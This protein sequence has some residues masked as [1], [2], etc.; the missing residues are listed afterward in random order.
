M[1]NDALQPPAGGVQYAPTSE[2]TVIL[3]DAPTG[4]TCAGVDVAE[5]DAVT[6]VDAPPPPAVRDREG[7]AEREGDTVLDVVRDTEG[8]AAHDFV[9]VADSE[10][11]GEIQCIVGK[12]LNAADAGGEEPLHRGMTTTAPALLAVPAPAG[13]SGSA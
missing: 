1:V 6:D 7:V 9:A 3:R 13:Y 12:R 5:I 4:S 11:D 8:D 10:A 2:P